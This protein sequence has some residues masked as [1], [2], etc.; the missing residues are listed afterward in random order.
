MTDEQNTDR[1]HA[2][3]AVRAGALLL[4]IAFHASVSFIP[5]TQI[6]PVADISRSPALAV[7]FFVLH[8]FRM[9][10]FF[11]I[12]GYFG[13]MM[14]VRQGTGGFVRDRLK[15]IALPLVVGWPVLFAAIV[16][17]VIWSAIK[18]AGGAALPAAP[19]PSLSAQ[20]FPLTHLWF[21]YALLWLYA[22]AL[23]LVGLAKVIDRSGRLRATIDRLVIGLERSRLTPLV[24]A[25]PICAAFLA[26]PEWRL[27][28]GVP[29]PDTGLVPNGI[30]MTAYGLAFGYGWLLQRNPGLLQAWAARWLFNLVPA[31]VLTIACVAIAGTTPDLGAAPRGS[32]RTILYAAA[33]AL[34]IWCW[35]I[36]LVGA[37]LRFLS[38]PNTTLRYMADASYWLY[39]IHLPIV[40]AL[41]AAFGQLGWPAPVKFALILFIAVP[42]ML[43]SYE[44][45]VRH[46]W[47]GAWLNGR[48]IPRRA[49][50]SSAVAP[51]T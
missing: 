1:L 22:G 26:N 48:R 8:L 6:W 39:L 14:L 38:R 34:A 23:C 51:A 18:A 3:D 43:A 29:T 17:V 25:V 49:A 45:L 16:A 32:A 15:R 24:I 21:L 37:A 19:P 36:G 30:A 7:A 42:L 40:M 10:A 41:Q 27:W 9:T 33:Y 5:G 12:A 4:G 11:L 46:S 28:F 31:I 20:T 44:L 50:H 2:L 35:T 13:R 47:I